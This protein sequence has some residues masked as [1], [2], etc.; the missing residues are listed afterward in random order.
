MEQPA[1]AVPAKVA[2]HAVAMLLGMA[3][4]CVG[5][6]AEAI[7]RPGLFEAEHQAFVGDI[8]QLPG[9]DRNIADE[10]HAAGIAVPAAQDRGYVDV[11]D[12]AVL[13]RLVAGNA[14]ADDMV[15]RGAAALGIAAI[16]ERGRDAAR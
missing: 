7:A 8:D 1:E 14:V 11:D 15:D 16:T 10:I 6:V 12:I 4:D 2:D 9:L 5:D 3:L 13:E